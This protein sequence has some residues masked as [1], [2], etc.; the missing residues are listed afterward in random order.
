VVEA[1]KT[2]AMELQESGKLIEEL[3]MTWQSYLGGKWWEET[4]GGS[5]E[6]KKMEMRTLH[7]NQIFIKSNCIIAAVSP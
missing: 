6:S 1:D 3:Q 7:Q 2:A 4:G 5:E